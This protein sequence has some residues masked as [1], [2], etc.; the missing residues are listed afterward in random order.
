AHPERAASA[1]RVQRQQRSEWRRISSWFPLFLIRRP[2]GPR[3]GGQ[4][5]NVKAL[6]FDLP[7]YCHDRINLHGLRARRAKRHILAPA[8]IIHRGQSLWIRFELLLPKD[9]SVVL[10]VCVDRAVA[11]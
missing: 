7:W 4:R 9:F 8:Q 5:K 6:R 10:I 3:H 1:V 11:P 2:G